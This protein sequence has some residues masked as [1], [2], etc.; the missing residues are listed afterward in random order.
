MSDAAFGI[1]VYLS[2]THSFG[3]IMPDNGSD[4]NLFRATS[5]KGMCKGARVS[6]QTAP[7]LIKPNKVN[8]VGVNI[9]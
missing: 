9:L 7:S 6:Y 4:D 2:D 1:I 5:I 8:A 3:F